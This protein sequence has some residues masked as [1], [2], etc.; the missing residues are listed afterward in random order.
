MSKLKKNLL[1]R[2]PMEPFFPANYNVH[3]RRTVRVASLKQR[4]PGVL[5]DWLTLHSFTFKKY[6]LG[7]A[8][9]QISA[10]IQK[11]NNFL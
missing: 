1:E 3:H 4:A 10:K 2:C 6:V 8:P 7:G 9:L 11:K 5:S